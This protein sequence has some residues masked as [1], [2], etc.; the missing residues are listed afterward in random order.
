MADRP[1]SSPRISVV[2]IDDHELLRGLLEQAL[3]ERVD[4]QVV[5][6]AGD[7]EGGIELC[8]RLRPDVVILDS[9]LPGQQG[10]D[11]VQYLLRVSPGS[12]VLM[13]SGTTNPLALRRAIGC[14]ARGFLPKSAPLREMVEGIQAVHAG[15]I[16]C[17]AGTRRL[18]QRIMQDLP[19]N[20]H[21]GPLSN[22]ERDVL[23]G[24][25][26]GLSSKEIAAQLGLSV[27]T[28]ENHRRR[29]MD[30]TGV[31]SIAGLTLL[32]VELGLVAAPQR[33]GAGG[34]NGRPSSGADVAEST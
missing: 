11:A 4:M 9:L 26:R 31:H 15:Q 2:I 12:R 21:E 14:G 19:G 33:A 27:F 23:A 32:A 17:G 13:F 18:I 5:G 28:V 34:A 16:F 7:A 29:I 20:P 8:G 3:N 10:P 30:R 6:Q 22:R 24:I 25:A 1:N